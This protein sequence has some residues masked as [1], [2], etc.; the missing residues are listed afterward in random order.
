MRQVHRLESQAKANISTDFDE[1]KGS[2]VDLDY[3]YKDN[4]DM[5]HD[6]LISK[7]KGDQANKKD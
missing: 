5:Y 4:L 1:G 7:D 6:M 3:M 2:K